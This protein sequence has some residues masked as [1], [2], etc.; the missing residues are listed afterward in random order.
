MVLSLGVLKTGVY[1]K[2]S[3]MK[4]PFHSTDDSFFFLAGNTTFFHDSL[5]NGFRFRFAIEELGKNFP[6]ERNEQS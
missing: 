2:L 1:W 6:L 4:E 5:F 3:D